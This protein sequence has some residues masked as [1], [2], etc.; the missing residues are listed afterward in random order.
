M[1]MGMRVEIFCQR[2]QNEYRFRGYKLDR[3]VSELEVVVCVWGVK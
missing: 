1:N 3:V 2:E